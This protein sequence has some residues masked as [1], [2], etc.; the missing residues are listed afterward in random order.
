MKSTSCYYRSRKTAATLSVWNAYM[1]L[2][3]FLTSKWW[4]HFWKPCKENWIPDFEELFSFL[5]YVRT[6]SEQF[7]VKEFYCLSAETVPV[8]LFCWS[9]NDAK[10]EKQRFQ[11]EMWQ[12]VIFSWLIH[13]LWFLFLHFSFSLRTNNVRMLSAIAIEPFP[14]L[15]WIQP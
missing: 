4:G 2:A 6:S 7:T 14:S 11:Y 13:K 5:D 12:A 3:H 15:L 9:L 10:A 8:V 1:W